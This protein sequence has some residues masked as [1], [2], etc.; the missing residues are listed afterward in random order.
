LARVSV[1]DE[2]PSSV[3]ITPGCCGDVGGV[4]NIVQQLLPWAHD[5]IGR[6]HHPDSIYAQPDHAAAAACRA[7]VNAGASDET[8][9]EVFRAHPQGIGAFLQSRGEQALRRIIAFA[10][11]GTRDDG[12]AQIT[13]AEAGGD[14]AIYV[15]VAVLDGPH[16]GQCF[17]QALWPGT[18]VWRWVFEHAG[19]A[20]PVAHTLESAR[21]LVGH[22]VGVRLQQR[23]P[24][25]LQVLRWLA[26]QVVAAIREHHVELAA[27]GTWTPLPGPERPWDAAV[28]VMA[29]RGVRV[30]PA[31]WEVAVQELRERYDA[32]HSQGD[33]QAQAQHQLRQ[34]N[35]YADVVLQAALADPEHR[36]RAAWRVG[37]WSLRITTA[38]PNLQGITKD[39]GLR[40]AVVP[41]PG[42]LLVVADWACSQPRIAAGITGDQ[43]L[44][45]ALAPGEDL[46]EIVGRMVSMPPALQRPVG[47]ALALPLLNGAGVRKLA[48]IPHPQHTGA[49]LTDA[50]AK[51]LRGF[52]AA[53]FPA[54]TT[55]RASSAAWTHIKSP[56]GHVVEIPEE[57]RNERGAFA[58]LVQAGEADALR[59]VLQ[60]ADAYM[61]GTGAQVVLV[62]HD[63]VVWEVPVQHAHEAAKRAERWMLECLAWACSPCPPAVKVEVRPA[64]AAPPTPPEK[65]TALQRP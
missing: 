7:L 5:L 63:E 36:V 24:G 37:S 18:S 9:F 2:G 46:Y 51:A 31:R 20:P 41:A 1:D 27:P 49:I 6:G 32:R 11:Q 43:A 50:E 40:A 64:W 21:A 53:T 65:L 15:G 19:L 38:R 45:A 56:L 54:L 61:A 16:A 13:C 26:P 33:P 29:A 34:L 23:E 39:G 48:S 30:D 3:R 47:K 8:I 44:I 35:G 62:N 55:Y 59:V 52:F 12:L 42:H 58:G 57:S 28:H 10:R 17:W 60:H 25:K 14:G 22:T 4:L